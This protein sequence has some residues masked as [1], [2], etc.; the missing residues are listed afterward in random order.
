MFIL[1]L[2]D[3]VYVRTC[4]Y[5]FNVYNIINN[6]YDE[7]WSGFAFILRKNLFVSLKMQYN[8]SGEKRLSIITC[9]AWKSR[10]LVIRPHV[11][12]SHRAV[13]LVK[14]PDLGNLII[15]AFCIYRYLFF[16][17]IYLSIVF[18]TFT[19][20]FHT[21]A[22]CAILII[23]E[24]F[25]SLS[26]NWF[27]PFFTSLFANHY[28]FCIFNTSRTLQKYTLRIVLAAEN[29]QPRYSYE[30]ELSPIILVV[31]NFTTV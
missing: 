13:W 19:S 28:I 6:M 25:F 11:Q 31:P 30:R 22:C 26:S 16:F 4:D 3:T 18:L 8:K 20:D 12:C 7:P 23:D 15:T 24:Q 21:N 29:I 10:V 1:L 9:G 27:D 14:I 5:L 2:P 17:L